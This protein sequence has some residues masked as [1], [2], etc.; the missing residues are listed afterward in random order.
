MANYLVTGGGGFIGSHL[1]ERLLQDGHRVRIL[2]D[3]STGRHAN[4]ESVRAAGP[5]RLQ[6][7]IADV[8]DLD[9]VRE[10]AAG[11]EGIFHLAALGSVPRSVENPRETNAVNTDGTLNVLVAAQ[12]QGVGRVVFAGS[13]SVYGAL[14]VSPKREDH[15]TRPVSPYG[16]TKLIGEEYLRLFREIHGMQTVTVRYY[17]VFGPRQNP[18]SQYAAVIPNFIHR[19]LRG[20]PPIVH[21]DGEQSRDFTYVTNAV[22]GSILAMQAPA[23]RVAAGVFNIATGGRHSLN[24]L[25]GELRGILGVEIMA[26]H[27]P[28]RAGDIRHSQADIERA[29]RDLGFVPRV[30]FREGL[31]RTVAYFR[32]GGESA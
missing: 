27:T 26:E 14:E 24:E 4:V 11:M 16:L 18:H 10:A 15:P 25:L 23:D 2:D 22:E 29:R 28:T 31:E 30:S 7:S 19:M 6:V 5:E 9:A 13:S 21:G 8:R 32:A 17:N 20:E 3:F 1:V 12:G